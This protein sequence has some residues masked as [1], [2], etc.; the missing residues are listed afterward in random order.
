LKILRAY[1]NLDTEVG[2]TQGMN[3]IAAALLICLNPEND[4]ILVK[5]I[6]YLALLLILLFVFYFH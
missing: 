1:S 4:K 2:Y 5:G 6:Y 3:Y